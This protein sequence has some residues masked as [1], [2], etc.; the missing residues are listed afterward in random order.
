MTATDHAAAAEKLL[1]SIAGSLAE[2][3]LEDP[4]A[5]AL[6]SIGQAQ[7]HATLAIEMQLRRIGDHFNPVIFAEIVDDTCEGGC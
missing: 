7:V 3:L 6:A 4:M 2:V 1:E 5:A